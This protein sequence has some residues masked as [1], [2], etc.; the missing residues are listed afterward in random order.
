MKILVLS[1]SHS[2]L[3]FMRRCVEFV[4]PDFVGFHCQERYRDG[5]D[6]NFFFGQYKFFTPFLLS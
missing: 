3:S 4:K 2:A 6:L 1:D 5:K